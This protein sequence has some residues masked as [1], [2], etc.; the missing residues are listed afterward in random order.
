MTAAVLMKFRRPMETKGLA[1]GWSEG[2]L[3]ICVAE[4]VQVQF[5]AN[6]HSCP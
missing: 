5:Q 3:A 1:L 2:K 4:T 6:P